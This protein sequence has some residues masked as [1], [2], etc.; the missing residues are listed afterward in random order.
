[1][2]WLQY[3]FQKEV[4]RIA[5][6]ERS[7]RSSSAPPSSTNMSTFADGGGAAAARKGAP[8]PATAAARGA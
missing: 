5:Q 3:S 7:F 1:M 8:S 2:G 4:R 6:P